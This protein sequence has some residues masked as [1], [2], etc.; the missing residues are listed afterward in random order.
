MNLADTGLVVLTTLATTPISAAELAPAN[1]VVGSVRTTGSVQLRGVAVSREGT[2]FAGDV[3]QSGAGGYATLRLNA[4]HKVELSSDTRVTVGEDG[5]IA[6]LAL[7]SGHMAFASDVA[8]P[9][10]IVIAPLEIYLNTDASG[11]VSIVGE[12]TVGVRVRAGS[13]LVRN[14]QSKKSF[15]LTEGQE[16]LIGRY[17]GIMADPI[18]LIASNLPTPIPTSLPPVPQQGTGLSNGARAAITAVVAGGAAVG[19]FVAGRAGGVDD[20]GVRAANGTVSTQ[21]SQIGSLNSQANDLNSQ[22]S[23]L[24]LQITSLTD[25]NNALRADL[26]AQQNLAN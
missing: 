10:S 1:G 6:Q 16:K 25:A 19:A 22:I 23:T 5:S 7:A 13:V 20:A 3:V 14:T 21:A 24:N 8:S 12:R 11:D 18:A 15:V 26:L 4:G 9:L 17:N 2:L